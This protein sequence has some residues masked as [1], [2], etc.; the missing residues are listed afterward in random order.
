MAELIRAVGAGEKGA[1]PASVVA[2]SGDV[3]HAY[4]AQVGFR[5][6]AGVVSSV[7]QVVCSPLRNP[8]DR[9]KRRLL[10]FVGS[11]VGEIVGRGLAAAARVKNPTIQWRLVRRPSFDN[12]I[13]TLQLDGRRALVRVEKAVSRGGV[14][15]LERVFEHRLA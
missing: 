11:R 6:N 14:P 1:A 4:L 10:R 2:L 13:G 12:Q 15:R 3:H 5:R 8:L 7:Y 9:R